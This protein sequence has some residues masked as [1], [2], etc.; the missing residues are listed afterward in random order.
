MKKYVDENY[1]KTKTE[2]NFGEK[3]LH[4]VSVSPVA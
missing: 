2:R 4:F 3:L 1:K